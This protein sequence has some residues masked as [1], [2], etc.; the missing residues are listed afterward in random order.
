MTIETAALE[1]DLASCLLLDESILGRLRFDPAE[2][3]DP[4]SRDIIEA[5]LTLR[6]IGERV[7]RVSVKLWLEDHGRK[8]VDPRVDD[9]LWTPK[10]NQ[11]L[12]DRLQ[13]RRVRIELQRALVC[14]ESGSVD[15]TRERVAA[16]AVAR[17]N[18]GDDSSR[19]LGALALA[20]ADA[21]LNPDESTRL[22]L[23]LGGLQ[24]ALG[25]MGVGDM[26]IVGADTG[27]G[28]SSL[29]LSM[30]MG[31]ER[32]QRVGIISCEDPEGIWG[33]RGLAAM[34]GVSS[35]RML[36]GMSAKNS[37][38][39]AALNAFKAAPQNPAVDVDFKVGRPLSDVLAGMRRRAAGGARLIIVDYLQAILSETPSAPRKDQIR[40]IA[41]RIKGQA[42]TLGV[43]L[44]A[45]SQL[46][47]PEKGKPKREPSKYDLKECGDLENMAEIILLM[48]AGNTDTEINL[49]VEKSKWG[50]RQ[51]LHNLRRNGSGTLVEVDHSHDEPPGFESSRGRVM[52]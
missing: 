2:L 9:T 30:A 40:E 25:G 16:I 21:A 32:R 37:D 13:L 7:D 4:P 52:Q 1:R 48:W 46:S 27:I 15:A 20:A 14:C 31:M 6:E 42:Q 35:L 5:A 45:L 51:R 28:K 50:C 8:Y 36:T 24:N 12:H 39:Q 41:A 19:P 10:A 11:M 26:C 17:E 23:G 3:S 49:K 47:R 44:V 33:A 34:T 43:G 38:D 18:I 22:H 29:A